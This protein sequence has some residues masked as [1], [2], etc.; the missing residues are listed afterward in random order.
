MEIRPARPDDADAVADVFVAARTMMPY[1]PTPDLDAARRFI[2][3]RVTGELETWV[4]TIDGAIAGFATLAGD[5]LDHLYVLPSEQRRGVGTAL[6]MHVQELRPHGLSFWVFQ[7][8]EG[9]RRFY[10]QHGCVLLFA[11]DGATNMEREPDARYA[12]PGA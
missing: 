5:E 9:A 12:W 10:E 7:R 2:R 4:A 1:L 8:N 3:E 6:F 11:T